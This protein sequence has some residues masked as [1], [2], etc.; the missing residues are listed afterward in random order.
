MGAEFC[1]LESLSSI[2]VS[3]VIVDAFPRC[4]E[5]IVFYMFSNYVIGGPGLL[6]GGSTSWGGENGDLHGGSPPP[7]DLS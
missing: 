4:S 5:N 2:G 3:C 6:H 7:V 1:V